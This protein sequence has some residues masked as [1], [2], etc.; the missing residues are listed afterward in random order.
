MFADKF[1]KLFP[2]VAYDQSELDGIMDRV[3]ESI[4]HSATMTDG[5]DYVTTADDVRL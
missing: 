3:T 4:R 5:K 2:S 1:S